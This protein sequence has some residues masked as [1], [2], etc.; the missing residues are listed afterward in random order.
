MESGLPLW[1]FHAKIPLLIRSIRRF[2]VVG[3]DP[4]GSWTFRSIGYHVIVI[5]ENANFVDLSLIGAIV[6]GIG[7]VERHFRSFR[8]MGQVH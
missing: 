7:E 6:S 8:V 4:L 2:W 3:L 5:V 1:H